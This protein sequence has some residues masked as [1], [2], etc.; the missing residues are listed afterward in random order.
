[1]PVNNLCACL[2]AK[3]SSTDEN[4]ASV[5]EGTIT[6]GEGASTITTIEI[7]YIMDY[8]IYIYIIYIYDAVKV[9]LM[10]IETN[11]KRIKDLLSY[12]IL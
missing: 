3:V 9:L 11:K 6:K 8:Y 7:I 1:M 12:L 4:V 10:E 5:L 2:V